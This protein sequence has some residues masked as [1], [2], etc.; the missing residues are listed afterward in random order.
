[1][2]VMNIL[3]TGGCG[4]IG[5]HFIEHVFK[6][7]DWNIIALD[8]LTYASNGFDRL[9]DIRVFDDKRIRCFTHD[10]ATPIVGGLAYELGP[11]DYIVH[12]AAETHV[13]NSIVN[14]RPFVLSNVLGTLEILEYART[15]MR[16]L[17]RLVY[18]STDEVFGPA[19]VGTE[20]KEWDRY[21]CT[22]PYSATKA[23]GEELALAYA[24]THGVPVIVTHTMNNFGER[25]HPEKFI[26]MCIS[27]VLTGK[28][29]KIHSNSDK[30]RPGSRFYLHARNASDAI[31]FLL[32]RGS[33]GDKYNVVGD[34]EVNNLDLLLYIAEHLGIE[35]IFE[36]VDF[37]SSRPGHDLRYALDGNKLK[38]MGWVAPVD[39]EQ[40]LSKTIDWYV[41]NP[42]WLEQ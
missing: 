17:R 26:P 25:Q 23:G 36:L 41:D 4:F 34:R 40:S 8:R 42:K 29:T 37:H 10:L 30:T 27:N 11:V 28:R 16:N 32:E 21:N 2:S 38:N 22:N 5:H 31:M 1:M 12:F 6:N 39:F 15:A 24:N 35:P 7:T 9:R 19:P 18:F 33:K 20:F 14:A 3:V 13:D